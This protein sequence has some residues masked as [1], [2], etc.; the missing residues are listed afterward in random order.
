MCRFFIVLFIIV[1]ASAASGLDNAVRAESFQDDSGRTIRFEKPFCKII[2]LYGAHTENLFRLGLDEEI[3]GV[4]RHEVYPPEALKKP[5]FHYREDPEKYIAASPDLVLV[6]PMIV[7]GYRGFVDK[8]EQAGITVVSLQP[9]SIDGMYDYWRR[10]GM[11][12]G[13]TVRAEEMVSSFRAEL[14]ALRARTDGLS[15]AQRKGVYFESIHSKMKTFTPDSM[16]VFVLECAGGINVAEGRRHHPG[17]EHRFLRQ[18]AHFGQG[19]RHR[20]LS[21]SNRP[22]EQGRCRRH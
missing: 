22:H 12:V 15:D 16:A 3:I 20:R 21:G 19:G 7:R 1:T 10:L 8:L 2:S 6:R 5:K 13:R 4:T 17:A 9:T 18:G 14:K 11:L